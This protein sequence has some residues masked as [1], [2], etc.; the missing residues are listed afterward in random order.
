MLNLLTITTRALI[1]AATSR[2][3]NIMRRQA[4][5]ARPWTADYR[6]NAGGWN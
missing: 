3:Y 4:E 6:S 2:A 5:I 1:A